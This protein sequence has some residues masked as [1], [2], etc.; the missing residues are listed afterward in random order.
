MDNDY[1]AAPPA[2][3]PARYG[4]KTAQAVET[5]RQMIMDGELVPGEH[6]RQDDLAI[7]L[8]ISRVP[9]REALKMI[10]SEGILEHKPNVGHYVMERSSG[11]LRQITWLR[12]NCE[13]QLAEA[14]TWPDQTHLDSMAALNRKMLGRKFTAVDDCKPVVK[15]DTHFHQQLWILSRDRIFAREVDK[16]WGMLVPYRSMM[17]YSP[18]VVQRMHDEHVAILAALASRDSDQ[19]ISALKMHQSH[20]QSYILGLV[21][22]CLGT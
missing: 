8:G 16:M 7:R 14:I 19:L 4:R 12:N 11:D 6:L 15:V 10:T 9:V 22:S 17:E 1:T 18:D 20:N 2:D 13:L 3:Q 21:P 5:I